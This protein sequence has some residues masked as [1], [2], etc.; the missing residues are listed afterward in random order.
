M[1]P[2]SWSP[3]AAA[4]PYPTRDQ[5]ASYPLARVIA[6]TALQRR[7][8]R[9]EDLD[10]RLSPA[11]QLAREW[12]YR[13]P[14]HL[15]GAVGPGQLVWVPFGGQYLQGVVIGLADRAPVADLRDIDQL[16]DPEPVLSEAHLHLALWISDYYLAPIH[17]VIQ[18]ML[19]PGLTQTAE[20]LFAL[21]PEDGTRPPLQDSAAEL[22]G[23]LTEAPRSARQLVA[24]LAALRGADAPSLGAVQ[25]RLNALAAAGYLQRRVRIR[26][27]RVRPKLSRAVRLAP[28]GD[29]SRWPPERAARQ[30][31]VLA[32]CQRRS[33][34]GEAWITLDELRAQVG[35][36]STDA[37]KTL[38]AQGLLE[39]SLLR[40]WRDPLGDRAWVP[41]IPPELTPDQAA[42][43]EAIRADLDR[44][45]G[46]PFLL[47]GV[48]GSGKTEVYLRAAQRALA[49]GRGAII[50]VPEIALTPQTI[51]RFGARFPSAIAVLHSGLTLGERLDQ[52]QRL[53]VG[54]LR[55]VIGARSAL[56]APVHPLGLIVLDEEHE[57]SYKQDVAPHYHAREAATRLAA[58]TG[59]TCILGSATPSLEAAYRAE[60]GDYVRLVLPQRVLGHRRLIEEQVADLSKA[61]GLGDV[62]GAVLPHW[63]ATEAAISAVG[64]ALYAELPPV[65]IV[66][67]RAELRAGNTGILSRPLHAAIQAAL[68]AREQVI[69]FLN[70]RGSATFVMCRD[71]GHVFGCPRC[72]V[73]LTHHEAAAQLIC[74]H[75]GRTSPI[76]TQCPT[77]S[78]KRVRYFGVGT[79]RVE[80]MVN[81][82]FAGAR[83]M[84][85][86]LDTTAGK[87]A[88][89]ALLDRFIR[90]E[91][92]IMVGTQMIAKG[93]DLPRVTLVGVI[94]ADTLLHLPDLRATERTFQ[95]L[96]QVAGRAGRSIL[97]GRVIIQTYAPQHPAIVAASQHDY[98]GFYAREIAFR[99]EHWY[100]PLSRLIH[101]VYV[102][103]SAT[104]AREEALAL[105][106]AL[107]QRMARMGLPEVDLIGPA[108]AF[109]ARVRGESRWHI[110]VR[111]ADPHALLR[112]LDL[113]LGWR[114]DVDPVSL[115]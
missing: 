45:G 98:N 76:P 6:L 91:A 107:A 111:G 56:F 70:R 54:E 61:Q 32:Y 17:L 67:M 97:G 113:P 21:A 10:E 49:Q 102:Q 34:E 3:E 65:E 66:D 104:R 94:T 47:Q 86:D 39:E 75:C 58:L 90:G 92:D 87:D 27:P 81:Q 8:F 72:D 64:E 89:E 84:R 4:A 11:S 42:I 62:Q 15:R 74:H 5:W 52:W 80:Q 36:T 101:L 29:L 110:I 73:P 60:R 108:P 77:C 38:L 25:A 95:L 99:R 40:V 112:G 23:L 96:T 82:T 33:L 51:R 1:A 103:A 43:W 114:I 18:T 19:P 109:F 106:A 53:R 55:L 37:A 22:L 105:H 48:T 20:T 68:Q 93:L 79:E 63:R 35:A 44:P 59:A 16:V 78:S 115:L 31:A 71:C 57:P 7:G 85:W 41:V 24:R 9:A 28:E 83:V 12:H 30:R 100:P 88:H 14:E 50:L 26:L 69:L 2:S 46:R 13:I